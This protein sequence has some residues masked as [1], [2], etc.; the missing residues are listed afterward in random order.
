MREKVD[1]FRATHL[2]V[3]IMLVTLVMLITVMM[4]SMVRSE[5]VHS[6]VLGEATQLRRDF[7]VFSHNKVVS[8]RNLSQ[9]S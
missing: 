5:S 4:V 9:E 6:P 7:T 8:I 2:S 1:I 3:I